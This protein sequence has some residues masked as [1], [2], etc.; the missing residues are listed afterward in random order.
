M[1]LLMVAFGGAAGALARYALGGWVQS[2]IDTAFPLGTFLVNILGSFGLGF[3]FYVLESL[4]LPTELRSLVTIGFL[5]AFTTFSTFSYE[6]VILM[7]G[8]EWH[9]AGVYI[10]G[11]LLLGLAGVMT[12]LALGSLFLQARG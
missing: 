8:G 11:S 1:L 6:A 5:G 9:R 7:E 12:G 4:A 10:G 3:S 2:Q